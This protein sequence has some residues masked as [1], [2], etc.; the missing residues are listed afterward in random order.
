VCDLAQEC[1]NPVIEP[2]SGRNLI[3]MMVFNERAPNAADCSGFYTVV[4]R[5]KH[6]TLCAATLRMFG[7]DAAEMPL[8]GTRFTHRR[9]GLCR[10][11]VRAVT[12]VASFRAADCT[13]ICFHPASLGEDDHRQKVA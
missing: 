7:D 8:I 1:F 13:A 2:Y 12:R 9:Q 10:R 3:P 5:W 4:L 6:L 11:M